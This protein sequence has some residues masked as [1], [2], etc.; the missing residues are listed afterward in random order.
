[1][2]NDKELQPG[3]YQLPNNCKAFVRNGKVIVSLKH[4]VADIPRCRDCQH[5]IRAKK[6][7]N[8]WYTSPVCELQPKTNRGYNNPEVKR[9]QR[10]Y[11]VRPCDAA[12]ERFTPKT[13]KK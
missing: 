6:Q 2:T 5:C 10:Y 8:Q 13:D 9:Q 4:G 7:Y 12:C 1:M 3:S 11:S